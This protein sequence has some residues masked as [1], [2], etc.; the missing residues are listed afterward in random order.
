MPGSTCFPAGC[1][2]D[3]LA[4]AVEV[5]CAE[6]GDVVGREQDPVLRQRVCQDAGV[7]PAGERDRGKGVG[8]T[9]ER[10]ERAC[11]AALPRSTGEHERAVDVEQHQLLSHSLTAELGATSSRSTILLCMRLGGSL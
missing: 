6:G 2:R 1:L 11:H 4:Q 5:T 3:F 7:G 8:N 9:E 10:L